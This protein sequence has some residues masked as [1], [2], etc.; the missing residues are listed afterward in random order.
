MNAAAKTPRKVSKTLSTK[1]PKKTDS[2]AIGVSQQHYW[3][4]TSIAESR[5]MSRTDVLSGI[6]Q[7]WI[8]NLDRGMA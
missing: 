6:I 8:H 4:I 5:N 3:L 1:N 2:F 7:K